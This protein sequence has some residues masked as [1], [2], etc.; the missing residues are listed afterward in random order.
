MLVSFRFFDREHWSVYAT[1]QAFIIL[2]VF[3]FGVN[4]NRLETLV[5]SSL[6]AMLQGDLFAKLIFTFFL[7]LI[8]WSKNE[9]KIGSLLTILAVLITDKISLNNRVH[10]LFYSNVLLLNVVRIAIVAWFIY[11]L[12]LLRKKI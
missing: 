5:F 12:F 4:I 2:S 9:F 11:I 1:I 8:V 3:S 10:K 7:S 6:I